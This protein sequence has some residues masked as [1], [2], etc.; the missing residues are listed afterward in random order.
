MNDSAYGGPI[1]LVVTS[2]AAP[3]SELREIASQCK[4][5]GYSFYV[6]GDVPSPADFAIDGCEFYSLERQR[7]TGLKIAELIEVLPA[8]V[9]RG[10]SL[11]A[12][13]YSLLLRVRFQSAERTL[14]DDEI[15]LWSQQ[16]V[17]SVEEL[18]GTLRA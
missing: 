3:N 8:E 16:I 13:T 2:I 14:R 12:G 18:G 5:R 6:I 11:A 17:K 9:F 10:G 1:S 15:N 4:A 7:T